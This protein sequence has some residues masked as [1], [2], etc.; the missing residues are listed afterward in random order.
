[1]ANGKHVIDNLEP[2]VFR[3]VIDGSDI[4]DL[5][6][7]GGCVVFKEGKDWND[8]RGR[9]VNGELIFPDGKAVGAC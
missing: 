2:L 7:F 9:N 6:E 5:G 8:T 1:V 4:A 3:R